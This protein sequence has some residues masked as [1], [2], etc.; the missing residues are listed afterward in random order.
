MSVV[1]LFSINDGL[2]T[3]MD[4]VISSIFCSNLPA[5]TTTVPNCLVDGDSAILRVLLSFFCTVIVFTISSYPIYLK[6]I[7]CSPSAICNKYFPSMSVEVPPPLVKTIFT[8][9]NASLV[10]ASVIVP[11]IF[12][13]F[14]A[15]KN[16]MPIINNVQIFL[17]YLLNYFHKDKNLN[18]TTGRRKEISNRTLIN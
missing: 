14:A 9:I 3:S 2:I 1:F 7:F 5:D 10:V 11:I 4:T 17:I 8:P 12:C 15:S 18:D 13:A 6:V 16:S